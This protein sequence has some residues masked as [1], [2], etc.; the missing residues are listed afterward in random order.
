MNIRN[1]SVS[2]FRILASMTALLFLNS[3][4]AAQT[5]TQRWEG[6]LDVKVTKLRIQL[7][8]EFENGEFKKGTGISPDQGNARMPLDSFVVNGDQVEFKLKS[9]GASFQGKFADDGKKM[10]GK[11]TQGQSFDMEFSKLDGE[12]AVSEHVETWKGTLVA[13]PQEFDF[14]LKF[15]KDQDGTLSARLDSINEGLTDL[16]LELDRKDDQCN[17]ELKSSMAQYEGTLNDAR[18]R[19]EGIWKQGGGEFELAFEKTDLKTTAKPL[20]PQHPKKPYPYVAEDV[21]YENSKAKITLAGTLTMPKTG[22]PFPAVILISGSGP[23]DRDETIFHH[24]PFLVI[25]DHLTKNGIAVLRFDDRGVGKSTGNFGESTS[26]DFAGD[27][28]AG[29]EFLLTRDDIDKKQIGLIGHSE[30][31]II[32]PMIAARRAD[33]AMI[34]LLAGPGVDGRQISISQSRA[35]AEAAGA[36]TDSLDKQDEFLTAV[37]KELDEEGTCSDEFIDEL[38]KDDPDTRSVAEATIAR[39]DSNWFKFFM[40][41]DPVPALKKVK[42]PVLVLNGKKDL[43]VLVDLNVDAIESALR[44][45]GNTSFETHKLDNMNHLFQET[46]GP[47]LMTDYGRLE[48]TFS[49]KALAIIS[50]WLKKV[51]N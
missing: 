29:I 7:E 47:G 5:D 12:F 40:N 13:G 31:G 25:A 44:D 22:G 39:L 23:Q 20:R 8:L 45:G 49:P 9:V 33:V 36:G 24:K 15:Y 17:F 16:Q 26:E 2:V 4:A 50:D 21:S 42:C 35:I 41:Y 34:V 1:Q 3:L 18:D 28:E 38:V 51:T 14:L 27:V 10:V 46:E 19:I 6:V 11:F 43:Q 30:G 37:F 48:E 32:A